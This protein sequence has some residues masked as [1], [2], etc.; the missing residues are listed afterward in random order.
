MCEEKE[1][2]RPAYCIYGVLKNQLIYTEWD[3]EG[4]ILKVLDLGN[5]QSETLIKNEYVMDVALT[6]PYIVCSTQKGENYKL[7]WIQIGDKEWTEMEIQDAAGEIF[8]SEDL[9]TYT[10]YDYDKMSTYVYMIHEEDHTAELIRKTDGDFDFT[11]C[12]LIDGI[13]IGQIENEMAMIP[14]EA[15]L[16]GSDEWSVMRI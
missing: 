16:S 4:N 10:V 13:L 12:I 3:G 1:Y 6:E 5:G 7:K 9:K 15:Y 14:L 11:P 2:M 8:W